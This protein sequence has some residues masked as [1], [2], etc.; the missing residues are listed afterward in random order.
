MDL[1]DEREISGGVKVLKFD[2]EKTKRNMADNL[3]YTIY[4]PIFLFIMII[5]ILK[6]D[7]AVWLVSSIYSLPSRL[8]GK[9]EKTK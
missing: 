4:S 5:A 3:N 6:F 8:L 9:K 1:S 7:H 2:I